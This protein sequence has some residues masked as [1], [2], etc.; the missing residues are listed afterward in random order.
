MRE[1][2]S[3]RVGRH[4]SMLMAPSLDEQLGAEHGIRLL[5]QL[6]KE[7][8]W[9]QWEAQYACEGAGRPPLHPRLMCGCILYGLLKGIRSTRQLEEATRMRIDFRWFLEERTVDH[10]TFAAFRNRFGDQIEGLFKALNR[11]AAELR[12]ATLEEVLIDGTRLRADSDRHG[13]R[14]AQVLE[15]KLG[16]LDEQI[17]EALLQLADS[18]EQPLEAASSQELQHRLQRLE[19]QQKKLRQALAVAQERDA[20]KRE[21]EGK[22]CGAVRVPVTDPDA[23]V[24]PN[25]EGGYAPNYT[26]V[27]GVDSGTGLIMAATVADGNA[28]AASVDPIMEQARELKGNNPD[29]VAFDGNFASGP[30]LETLDHNGIEVYAPVGGSKQNNPAV[31]EDPSVPVPEARHAQ[32]PRRGGKLERAAFVYDHEQ[33]RYHCPMGRAIL[34]SKNVSRKA[35]DGTKIKAVE[36]RCG[37]C[38][39]CPLAAECL[40]KG[41]QTRSIRRDQYE[42]LR[43]TID[44]RN[45]TPKGKEVYGRRAPVVEGVFGTMKSALGFRRF[46]RRGAQ[47]VKADWLWMCTAYNLF[48]LLKALPAAGSASPSPDR[49]AYAPVAC[50]HVLFQHLLRLARVLGFMLRSPYTF[51]F[52]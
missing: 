27:V 48:K 26:P 30:N 42:P 40:S 19:A 5:D 8:D 29:R 11:K 13:A 52:A 33:D 51:S 28:E 16:A 32:L 4:E 6:L 49:P 10:A 20:K 44:A 34:P 39:G 9:S 41:A 7:Q 38:Q 45:N 17:R 43:E 21:K 1:W 47:K 31:R 50:I 14:T 35:S 36:Y 18:D 22:K 23:H 2:A 25:K 15:K 3:A 37:D 12:K 24:L 46:Q